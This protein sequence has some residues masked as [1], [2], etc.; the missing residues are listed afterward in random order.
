MLSGRSQGNL[1]CQEIS[2]IFTSNLAGKIAS[3]KL[4]LVALGAIGGELVG[5]FLQQL[6]GIA[7]VDALALSGGDVVPDPLPE[8]AAAYFSGGG[9]FLLFSKEICQW[10]IF[11]FTCIVYSEVGFFLARM[12]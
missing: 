9:V 10:H 4:I 8:L 12:G 6:E 11:L 7:L 3:G 2:I 1:R 5:L